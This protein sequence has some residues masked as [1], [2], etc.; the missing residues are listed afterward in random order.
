MI[1]KE[2]FWMNNCEEKVVEQ[3]VW[4]KDSQVM[5]MKEIEIVKKRLW[6]NDCERN[7]VKER[8]WKK[9]CKRKNVK[10]RLWSNCG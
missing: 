8:L 4:G 7:I 3:R 6:K 9:D 1:M 10:E 2:W 5:I